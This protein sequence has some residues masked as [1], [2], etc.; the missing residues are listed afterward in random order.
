VGLNVFGLFFHLGGNNTLPLSYVDNCAE[1]IVLA[2]T[3]NAGVG[4]TFN[5]HDDDL[6]TARQYLR[7]FRRDVKRIRYISIPYAVTRL[8]S[9]MVEGY[10]RRSKG[11]LPDVFTP[12]KTANLWKATRF[13]NSKLKG[14]G[15]RQLVSTHDGLQRAFAWLSENAGH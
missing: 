8:M 9:S 15:W 1:A 2:S 7:W 12:Y 6:P 10:H 11:Q 14:F 3:E 5:V 13:D 4:Q